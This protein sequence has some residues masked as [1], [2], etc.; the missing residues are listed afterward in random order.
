VVDGVEVF[1]RVHAYPQTHTYTHTLQMATGATPWAGKNI[2]QVVA[3]VGAGRRPLLPEEV[4][5]RVRALVERCWAQEPAARPSAA[6]LVGELAS[7][8]REGWGGAEETAAREADSARSPPPEAVALAV[9]NAF[10][11]L[12]LDNEA[13]FKAILHGGPRGANWARLA[14]AACKDPTVAALQGVQRAVQEALEWC[15]GN[16]AAS[17]RLAQEL[18]KA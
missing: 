18:D 2:G 7:L 11:K 3:A 8:L 15:A 16:L 14:D 10:H 6:A 9:Q 4:D 13:D 17:E 5:D 12:G 1:R